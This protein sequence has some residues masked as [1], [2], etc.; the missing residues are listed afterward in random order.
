MSEQEDRL[1]RCFASI[2]PAL[3]PE[4]IRT[5][6]TKSVAA[7]D[8]LAAVTLVAVVQQ[9]FDVEIDL[10]DLPELSSFEALRSYLGLCGDA[11]P[12]RG[13]NQ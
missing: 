12:S 9:E 2:F 6:S 3:T 1:V 10:L 7:W 8:S 4:E 5:A 13:T 11:G